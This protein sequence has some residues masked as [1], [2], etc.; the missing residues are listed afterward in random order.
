MVTIRVAL[1]VWAIESVTP[2]LVP[3]EV[4]FLSNIEGPFATRGE[5]DAVTLTSPAKPRLFR[6]ILDD[7][8]LPTRKFRV[9]GLEEILKSA[10]TVTVTTTW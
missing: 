1:T 2:K 6:M 5:I 7:A 3:V 10:A 9:V 4:E 8:D